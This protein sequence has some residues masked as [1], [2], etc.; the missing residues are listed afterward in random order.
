MEQFSLHNLKFGQQLRYPAAP[1]LH[2]PGQL[3]F[4]CDRGVCMGGSASAS[5]ESAEQALPKLYWAGG[6]RQYVFQGIHFSAFIELQ[7]GKYRRSCKPSNCRSATRTTGT[8]RN[9]LLSCWNLHRPSKQCGMQMVSRF[10]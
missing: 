9:S 1:P 8:Q 4:E 3:C 7:D 10:I 6:S 5:K 2:H